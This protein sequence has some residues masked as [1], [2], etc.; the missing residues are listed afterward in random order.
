MSTQ[1]HNNWRRKKFDYK[2]QIIANSCNCDG[3]ILTFSF[4]VISQNFCVTIGRVKGLK[5]KPFS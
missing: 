2:N 5:N 3:H 1:C 4:Y